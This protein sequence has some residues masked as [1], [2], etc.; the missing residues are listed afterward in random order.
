MDAYNCI[1]TRRSIRKYKNDKIDNKIIELLLKAGSHAPSANNYQEWHFIVI[2]ETELLIKLSDIH[3]HGKML[4]DAPLAILVCADNNIQ[5]IEGYQAIDCAAATENI[6]LAAYSLGLGGVWLGIFPRK[7]R[8]K[9][10]V[11]FFNLPEFITPISLISIGY[12]NEEKK[13][14]EKFYPEKIHSNKW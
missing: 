9:S 1:I 13:Q 5:P 2:T 6:L 14:P 3:P 10:M 8:M 4:K 12:P 7:E 11:D